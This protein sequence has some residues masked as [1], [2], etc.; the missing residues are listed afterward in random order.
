MVLFVMLLAIGGRS[1][2]R[3]ARGLIIAGIAINLFGAWSFD[4]HWKYYRVGG[5]AY[6]VIIRH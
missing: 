2:S 4:R 5:D 1:L 3:V 6:D